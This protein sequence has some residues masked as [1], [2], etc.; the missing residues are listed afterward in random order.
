MSRF[1]RLLLGLLS[2]AMLAACSGTPVASPLISPS[3][4]PIPSPDPCEVFSHRPFYRPAPQ[5]PTAVTATPGD[6]GSGAI[7]VSW[8][9]GWLGRGA[10]SGFVITIYPGATLAPLASPSATSEAVTGL[11][12]GTYT[13]TVT[14]VGQCDD[15]V[16]QPSTAVRLHATRSLSALAATLAS[17]AASS[18]GTVGI[19]FSELYTGGQS[20]STNG[21]HL[22]IAA[23]TYKLPILM[24]EA[25]GIAN[26]SINPNGTICYSPS[27][28][29]PGLGDVAWSGC[30]TRNFLAYRVAHYS[31][32]TA[33]HML[34]TDL[35]G[36]AGLNA[37]ARAH[38]AQ[39]PE[40]YSPNY[41]DPNDLA[42]LW[43]N[44]QS[45]KAGGAAAQAWLYPLLTHT[46]PS[47]EQGIP[48]G[49]PSSAVV[50]HKIGNYGPGNNDAAL[51]LNGPSGPYVLVVMTNGL[52]GANAN[53]VMR[54]LAAATWA[55][56]SL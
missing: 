14:A 48:A 53:A 4:S 32:N 5:A 30:Y 46:D 29:E 21:S 45:G 15:A 20:W 49:V 51:I 26:G 2:I 33:A 9:Q 50:V 19:S 22:F 28:Y 47:H 54:R 12:P 17:D 40:L 6:P 35:G 24:F 36:G 23:S 11:N 27:D 44:E 38:G 18:G 10:F 41:I 39:S 31:N 16:S 55:Y 34:V 52:S 8:K 56:E 1:P 7:T 25:Q 42:A 3:T 37:Y 43:A 13:F